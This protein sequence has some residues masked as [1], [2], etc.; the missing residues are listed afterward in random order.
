MSFLTLNDVTLKFSGRKILSHI[1]YEINEQDF[2]ILLGSNGSGKSSLLK[3]MHRNY[4]PNQ[5][6]IQF[7][8]KPISHYSAQHFSKKVA[9]LTQDCAD[10]LFYALTI[11]EN[12]LLVKNKTQP[13]KKDFLKKYLYDFN[14]ILSE[15]CDQPIAQLSGGQKQALALAFCLLTPPKLLLLDEHTSALDPK[16]SQHIMALTQKHIKQHQ[17]T[18]VL[19]THNLDMALEYGNRLLV[20]KHGNVFKAYDKDKCTLTK[21]DLLANFV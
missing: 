1:N 13:A 18:C 6:D 16:T 9:V 2:I 19:T 14:P 11:Y 4:H 8:G 12:Y 15:K 10:S 17:I 5:G 7:L 3:L 21:N 20:L